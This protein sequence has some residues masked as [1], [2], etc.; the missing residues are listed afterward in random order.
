MESSGCTETVKSWPKVWLYGYNPFNLSGDGSLV[1]IKL[2]EYIGKPV[3]GDVSYIFEITSTHAILAA[4]SYLYTRS[5]LTKQSNEVCFGSSIVKLSACSW[6]CLVL[7]EN[8]D[9]FK[10]DFND[11][12][13]V[14][15]DFL[16]VEFADSDQSADEHEIITHLA[17]GDRVSIATTS[18]KSVFTIPSR[19]HTFPRHVRIVQIAVGLEHCLLLTANGDV[20]SWGGGLRGQLGNGEIFPHQEQPQ[21]VEA[22]AGVKIV[23]IAAG[24]WHSGAI[25]SFGDLYSWGW[26]SKGQLGIVDEKRQ[27]GSVFSLPQ[28][29][30]FADEVCLQRIFCGFEHTLVVDTKG[31]IY[32]TGN[33][34]RTR[35]DY[36]KVQRHPSLLGF[37]KMEF[38][39]EAF[40][41]K[42][43]KSGANTIILMDQT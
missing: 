25:S 19:I 37:K 43:I 16:G 3:S 40:G 35:L 33:D 28:L 31:D 4:E 23:E 26:N 38:D 30:E 36:S 41:G 9:L 14:R 39:L 20:Y 17:C 22:L 13:S 15:L 2:N 34:L 1:E 10:Y 42:L 24:G 18:R 5:E 7:L 6:Y 27:K 29:I 32:F 12:R 21:L 11:N 8:C